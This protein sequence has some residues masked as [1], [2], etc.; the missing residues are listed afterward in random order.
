MEGLIFTPFN[1][2]NRGNSNPMLSAL[3]DLFRNWIASAFLLYT[4]HTWI[5]FKVPQS[6]CNGILDDVRRSRFFLD[7]YLFMPYG[8]TGNTC[9]YSV[10]LSFTIWKAPL[11]STLTPAIA[12]HSKKVSSVRAPRVWC[13]WTLKS[14]ITP[15]LLCL[16][17]M[18]A[19]ET[20]FSGWT[21]ASI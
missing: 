16:A 9:Q 14:E 12:I 4:T 10:I 1:R 13:T 2:V 7:V 11:K 3:D 18:F 15:S 6:S 20:S 8:S 5:L 17:Q 19:T 21:E